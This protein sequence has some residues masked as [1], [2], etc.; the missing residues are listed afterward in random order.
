MYK[1]NFKIKIIILIKIIFIFFK[2]FYN[3][4]VNINKSKAIIFYIVSID[5]ESKFIDNVDIDIQSSKLHF[6]ESTEKLLN[7]FNELGIKAVFFINYPEILI[8]ENQGLKIKNLIKEIDI[9]SHQVGL[10]IHPSLNNSEKST[11]LS[12]YSEERI[13]KMLNEGKRII[14]NIIGKYPKVFRAGGYSIGKWKKMYKCLKNTGF[15]ID[16]SLYPGAKNL[17]NAEFDFTGVENL[18]V[19]FPDENDIRKKN[20]NG[21]IKE[22]PITTIIKPTNNSEAAIF[23]FD[24]GNHYYLLKLYYYYFR[25][26]KKEM[27]IN[28]IFHSKHV[29]NN[30]YSETDNYIRLMKYVKFL[31]KRAINIVYS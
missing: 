10:H 1:M 13:I 29:Y 24:L 31:K 16:S 8:L 6:Y 5:I 7:C 12:F 4:L 30:N 22:Y 26:L 2:I 3:H 18:E 19:F 28:I 11:D 15:R 9:S 23:R 21:F 20:K 25:S 17:H 14:Y 27:Y